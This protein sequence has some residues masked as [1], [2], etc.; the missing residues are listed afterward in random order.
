MSLNHPSHFLKAVIALVIAMLSIQSGAALA[1]HI[2]HTTGPLGITSL[3]L[4]FAAIIL[5]CIYR[6]W[7]RLPSRG[8]WKSVFFYGA[9]IGSMNL[10]FYL[11]I[12]RIPLGVGIALEFTGPLAIALLSSRNVRD[13]IWVACAVAGV[14]L[15]LPLTNITAT[16]DFAGILYAL[17]AGFCWALYIIF[18]K[19]ISH[20][21]HGG[22]T[23]TLGICVA[24]LLLFPAGWINMGNAIF[25]ADVLPVAFAVAVLSSALPYP[26]EMVALRNLP[27][28]TFSILTSLEPAVGMASGIIFLNE[29]LSYVH[30]I[31][32]GLIITASIGSTWTVKE[33][34][35]TADLTP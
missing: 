29:T 12:A 13:F 7:N 19:Q 27:T 35:S 16:I 23:T 22:T 33:A 4:L 3:R 6:P 32:I 5:C 1:K 17:G 10:L 31:A 21:N 28:R 24:A 18:G 14:F 2:F 8:S 9:S 26:L 34:E 11:A 20:D 25:N 30:C 15:L